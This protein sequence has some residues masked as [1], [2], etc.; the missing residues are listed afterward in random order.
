MWSRRGCLVALASRGSALG[1]GSCQHWPEEDSSHANTG[2]LDDFSVGDLLVHNLGWTWCVGNGNL[3][4]SSVLVL[5][6]GIVESRRLHGQ[7]DGGH[8][9]LTRA[10]DQ[11]FYN[12]RH[13]EN[14]LA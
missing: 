14:H 10:P 12:C 13:A 6:A 5:D 7:L 3:D 11:C 4:I 8:V 1:L 2:L 9:T